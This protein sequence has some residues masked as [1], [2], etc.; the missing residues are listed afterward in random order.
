MGLAPV[1]LPALLAWVES[2]QLEDLIYKRQSAQVSLPA[3]LDT[4]PPFSEWPRGYIEGYGG[5]LGERQVF[6]LRALS[7][8][9]ERFVRVG[10][11]PQ[12]QFPQK[13]SYR[14]MNLFR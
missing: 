5:I 2:H 14:E 6:A 3:C 11:F 8:N 9:G 7:S 4:F 1:E 13:A 10:R 12:R